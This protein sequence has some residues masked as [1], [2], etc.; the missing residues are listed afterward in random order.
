MSRWIFELDYNAD[1]ELLADSV[2]ADLQDHLT[3]AR[4][5][6]RFESS[7]LVFENEDD[8]LAVKLRFN[9]NIIGVERA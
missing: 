8:A 3:G 6:F 4:G 9:D 1:P 7:R 5:P 2:K